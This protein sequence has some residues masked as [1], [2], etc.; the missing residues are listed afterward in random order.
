[1]SLIFILGVIFGGLHFFARHHAYSVLRYNTLF[2]RMVH[3]NFF[4]LLFGCWKTMKY[5]LALSD[6]I[7]NIIILTFIFYLKFVDDIHKNI[8]KRA[9]GDS[10]V[11][12]IELL[13]DLLHNL[14]DLR[15]FIGEGDFI[16][17]IPIKFFSKN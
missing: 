14:E 5:F 10:H 2:L 15:H 11:H 8:L 6:F 9:V 16:N 1:M 3:F 13:L 17:K 12:N 7:V 4:I